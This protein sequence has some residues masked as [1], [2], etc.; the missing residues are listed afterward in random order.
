MTKSRQSE[1]RTE[2]TVAPEFVLTRDFDMPREV[3]WKMWT[4]PERV[5][6]WWGP[7]GFTAPE[8]KIDFREG[9]SCLYDMRDPEGKDYWSA[10]VY[11]EIAPPERIVSTDY[12]SDENGNP[13]PPSYYGMRGDAPQEQLV[14]VTFAEPERGK[15]RLTIRHPS[16]RDMDEAERMGWNQSFDKLEE[17]LRITRAA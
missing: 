8:I 13:V 14:T 5:K 11:R 1:M 2:G 3:I 17:R 16:N 10:G 6:Q 15:T 7:E 9:G 12:F 4:D